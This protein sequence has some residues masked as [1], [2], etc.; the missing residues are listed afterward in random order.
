MSKKVFLYKELNTEDKNCV[1]YI[2]NNPLRFEDIPHFGGHFEGVNLK[3]SCFTGR[4][5]ALEGVDYSNVVTI[6]SKNEF[7]ILRCFSRDIDMLGGNIELNDFRYAKGIELCEEV[8]YIYDKLNSKENQEL[9][10]KI[11]IEEKM[12]ICD[13]YGLA[14]GYVDDIFKNYGLEYKDRSVISYMFDD[15]EKFSMEKCEDFGCISNKVSR[16]YFDYKSYGNG[17]MDNEK[18]QKIDNDK[19][20][21]IDC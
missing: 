19:T 12:F 15:I 1:K 9:F 11:I 21:Q 4:K 20:V 5:D 2:E 8:M 3:G 17:L 16:T 10:A 6:L 7:D 13:E 14:D 18:S